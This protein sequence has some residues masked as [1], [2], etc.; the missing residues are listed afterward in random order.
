MNCVQRNHRWILGMVLLLAFSGLNVAMAQEPFTPVFKPELLTTKATGEIE[1]D[2]DLSDP[3]W[4]GLPVATNFSE[5]Q[6]GDNIRPL[7]ETRAYITYDDE[8]LYVAFDCQDNPDDIRATMC[9]RDQY[10]ND[11]SVAF[12]LDTYGEAQWA[13]QFYVNP[14]GIQ[15]DIQWSN[16]HGGDR[17]FDMIWHSSARITDTGYTVEIAIPF[18]SLRFPAGETQSWKVD[19]WRTQPR[20]S[21]HLY[22][23]AAND[24]NDQCFPCQ[25][26]TVEGINGV[27]PGRGLEI[28][29]SFIGYQTGEIADNTDP[30]SDFENADAE[31]EL[32]LGAKYKVSSDVTVEGTVNPD[33]S[34]IEA[35]AAQI[36]VNS[37]IVQRYPER[38]PFFQEGS[39][40]FRTM[41]NSF[42]TRMV[43]A[44][45]IAAKGTARWDKASVAYM[46]ARDDNSPY[47][48]P[49]EEGSYTAAPGRS[50]VHVLRGLQSLGNSS[51]IGGMLTDRQYSVGGRG[52]IAS[53]DARIR[54]TNTLSWMGQYVHSYTEE[55]GDIEI[56]AGETFADRKHTVDLDGEIYTGGAY[57]TELRHNSERW[58]FTLDYNQVG[59][60]YRTQTGYDPWNDQRNAFIYT[61]YDFNFDEGLIERITPSIFTN[62]RWNMANERKWLHVNGSV[63]TSLRWAQTDIGIGGRWGD[64]VWGGVAFK[65]LWS[66]NMNLGSRPSDSVGY[67]LAVNHGTNPALSTYVEGLEWAFSAAL[68]LKPIDSLIIEPTFDLIKSEDAQTGELLYEQS[69]ARARIRWQVDPRLSLRLVIQHNKAKSPGA[70]Q[71]ALDGDFPAY[72]M[73]LGSKWELDPLITYRINS[74]SVFF[75]GSTHDFHDF[76]AAFAERRSNQVLTERQ[77][78]MKLQ[79]LFQL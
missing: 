76:N 36:D 56:N 61:N 78:F 64:E 40:L 69:I 30:D 19:F 54:L 51:Q 17:G 34:Q 53:L 41:F 77:Y 13:Y 63:R 4:V 18:A 7:V 79:Y 37:S 42:Y 72:H 22:S 60:T 62:A 50:H 71:A 32:T 9:Q 27:E 10:F 25:W 44:P 70:L 68:D 45:E 57:I 73:Y 8:Y 24:R 12:M 33:F 75:L 74:F 58:N 29:P 47:M 1:I 16:V 49:T 2:G 6:P 66:V 20:E 65:D 15:K 26:G 43:N 23:W 38:R 52:T 28:L 59:Q 46:Y 11:D 39:D 31:G 14:Y 21:N 5:R 35:D 3:G 48:I 55:P 67:F